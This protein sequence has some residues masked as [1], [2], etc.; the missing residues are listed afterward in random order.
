MLARAGLAKR[1]HGLAVIRHINAVDNRLHHRQLVGIEKQLGI[2]GDKPAF[3]P[4]A[5]VKHEIHPALNRRHDGVGGFIGGLRIGRLRAGE[6]SAGAERHIQASRQL[7]ATKQH[8][9]R[10]GR[11]KGG[12]TSLHRH[13]ACEAAE[14][15]RRAGAHKLGEGNAAQRLGECLGQRAG[16]RDRRHRAG[17]DERR[18]DAGLVVARIDLERPKHGAVPGHRRVR[19]DQAGR[20]SIGV[21]EILAKQDF[22]HVDRVLRAFRRGDRAHIGLVGVALVGIDHLEMPLGDR[23]VDRLAHGSAGMVEPGKHVDQL[24]EIA[25]ILDGRIAALILEI[26]NE[27]RA[28]DRRE[29][30]VVAANLD[31]PGRVSR[32]LGVA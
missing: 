16:N 19:V 31:R 1:V 9:C 5:C 17:E 13:R 20:H 11:A 3:H 25:E 14:N 30:H 23:K 6:R 29:H 22:R 4:A 26:A 18:G 21:E 15:H 8:F 7:G 28:V 12:G 10:L 24:H 27:W 2:V 32:M